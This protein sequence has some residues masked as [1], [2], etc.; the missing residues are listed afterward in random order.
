MIIDDVIASVLAWARLNEGSNLDGFIMDADHAFESTDTFDSVNVEATSDPS[1]LLLIRVVA[2]ET[3]S[4][5]QE[6]ANAMQTA[7]SQLVYLGFEA[8]MINRYRDATVMRFV[9]ASND[10]HLC[11]TGE[12]VATSP[13][14]EALVADYEANFSFAGRIHSR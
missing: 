14:Y 2:R 11:V 5:L 1:R 12:V 9:T 7:W 4:T 10:G 3:T 6:I 13:N 8:S